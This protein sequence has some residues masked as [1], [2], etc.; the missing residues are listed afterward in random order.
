MKL[1]LHTKGFLDALARIDARKEREKMQHKKEI[2]CPN[3]YQVYKADDFVTCPSCDLNP[4]T[5]ILT[6][7]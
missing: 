7:A 1:D 3:C 6:T 4:D 2:E 5:E